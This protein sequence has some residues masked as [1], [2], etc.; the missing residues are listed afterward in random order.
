MFRHV[1]HCD[2]SVRAA[3]RWSA[4]A[5]RGPDGGWRASGPAGVPEPAAL[6]RRL[7]A[8]AADGPTL[9]AFDFPIGFPARF[10]AATGYR[11]FAAA[12][13]A[14]AAG[15]WPEIFAVAATPAEVGPRRPFYPARPG[16]TRLAHL[17]DGHGAARLADLVRECERP[18]PE[19]GAAGCMF[20]T[21]G[22]QQVGKA[23]LHGWREVIGPARRGGAA[24]WPF[25]GHLAAL[26]QRGGLVL[27]E[28]YPG[29]G[30]GQLGFAI[31]RKGDRALRAA[32]APQ[33]AA[34][35]E[36]RRVVLDEGLSAALAA[37]F[38]PDAGN[39][40][41]FDAAVGLLA[42]L[43]V[44][45]GERAAAPPLTDATRRW[46]GWILGKRPGLKP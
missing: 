38:P 13:D 3:G 22:A 9:A 21:L 30:Y 33:I 32:L 4:E 36:E 12:L 28:S 34:W 45:T 39:D 20:W 43:A 5:H 19:G 37:G 40:D 42:A 8:L 17:L 44:V 14:V 35:A 25:E 23:A 31:R 26:A 6:V 27:A 29:D 18:G 24:L 16:G 7:G 1:V 46:E 41:G 10:G 11:D 15:D 2:W